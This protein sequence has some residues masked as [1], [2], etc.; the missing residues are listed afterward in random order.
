MFGKKHQQRVRHQRLMSAA[1]TLVDPFAL[2][3]IPAD[4]V[5]LAFGR[6]QMEITEEEAARYLDAALVERG[7]RLPRPADVD[8]LPEPDAEAEAVSLAKDTDVEA[9]PTG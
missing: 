2:T 6:Y 9:A 3:A 4:L 7:E 1:K 5:A 8:E